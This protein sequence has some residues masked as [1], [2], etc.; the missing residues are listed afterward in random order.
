MWIVVQF[1]HQGHF[2]RLKDIKV[3]SRILF[4]KNQILIH[5]L[6]HSLYL[7]VVL[8]ISD[9]N[10]ESMQ[11]SFTCKLFYVNLTY[12]L[13]FIYFVMYVCSTTIWKFTLCWA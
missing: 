6:I 5:L 12:D 8:Q 3:L 10:H 7:F 1:C 9:I 13:S 11:N 4:S 2:K